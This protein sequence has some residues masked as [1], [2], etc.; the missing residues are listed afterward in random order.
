VEGE[1]RVTEARTR[2]GRGHGRLV[3]A[4]LALVMLLAAC[5][6]TQFRADPGHSGN[7]P[8]EFKIGTTNVS[9][10]SESWTAT[11]WGNPAVADGVAYVAD[12]TLSAFDAAGVTNCSGT[13]KSCAPL[14]TAPTAGGSAAVV[15]GIVYTESYFGSIS[16]G[17]LD[18]FDAAGVRNCS[19]VPKRCAP[20]W[21]AAL[22][23]GFGGLQPLAVAGGIVYVSSS[24]R[25][26]A[27]DAAGVRNCSGSPKSCAPLWTASSNDGSYY[28]SP[29]VA[30]GV[31]YVGSGDGSLSAF[32]AAGVT[33]CSGVPK[34]C[35]PLWTT[36]WWLGTS[37]S[38]AVVDGVVYVAGYDQLYAFDA[39]GVRS[40][41]G[42]PKVCAPLWAAS[43]G[44]SD[45]PLPAVANGVVYVGSG[46]GKLYAFDA[47]TG[48]IEWTATGDGALGPPAVANGVIY[49]GSTTGRLYA[50]DAAGA[51]SCSGTPK[52]CTPLWSARWS[53]FTSGSGLPTPAVAS[54]AVY[55]AGEDGKLHVFGLPPVAPAR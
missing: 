37:A 1:D 8:L 44:G 46:N 31:V 7:Q 48:I 23:G 33:S 55:V 9:A 3:A 45:R 29:A 50:F 49:V 15:N 40:C 21:T 39:A 24:G 10:L 32:D 54:G 14:W 19:G 53:A 28:S 11:S 17:T 41:S 4:A 18:A 26:S 6:W 30:T 5:N 34:T 38:P 36:F 42:N 22:N 25:L 43:D 27:F 35:A 47:G 52:T 12:G 2:I 20:L 16:G 51:T 13:P